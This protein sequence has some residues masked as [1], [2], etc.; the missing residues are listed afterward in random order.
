[1]RA[2]DRHEGGDGSDQFREEREGG[3]GIDGAFGVAQDDDA[4]SGGGEF[5]Y[6]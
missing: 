3:G 2:L 5:E 6:L 4:A 1:V